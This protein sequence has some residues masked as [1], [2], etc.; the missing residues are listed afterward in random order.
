MSIL[1]ILLI[2]PIFF[3]GLI[4]YIMTLINFVINS[5]LD[6][7]I[8]L[9]SLLIILLS[10]FFIPKLFIK[11]LPNNLYLK[12]YESLETIYYSYFCFILLFLF[13]VANLITSLINMGKYLEF[14]CGIGI[15]IFFG[16]I[17][18]NYIFNYKD[19]VAEL[20]SIDDIT[21]DIKCLDFFIE[22]D[23]VEFYSKDSSY[24]EKSYYVVKYNKKIKSIKKILKKVINVE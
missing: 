21:N 4:M 18:F 1:L 23:F 3:V 20:D 15:I 2:I 6:I 10:Y 16:Y 17:T 19:I 5:E 22:D 7:V 13:G 24:E 11:L 8:L 12:K 9:T 14:G